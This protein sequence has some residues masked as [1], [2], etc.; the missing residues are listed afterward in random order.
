MPQMFIRRGRVLRAVGLAAALVVLTTGGAL[1]GAGGQGTLTST[2]QFRNIELFP[3]QPIT[4]PC[5]GAT[6]TLS[7]TARTG[8][9]HTTSFSTGPELWITSTAEGTATF[10]PDDPHGVTASGHFA[11]WF[12][13]SLNN[14]NEASTTTSMFQLMGTDGS[15]IHV[16][17]VAHVSISA[18]G[19]VTVASTTPAFIADRPRIRK[20]GDAS[21]PPSFQNNQ[22]AKEDDMPRLLIAMGIAMAALEVINAPMIDGWVLAVAFAVMFVGFSWWFARGGAMLPAVLLGVMFAI[23]LA[24]LPVYPRDTLL[25]WIMQG[26]TLVL[27]GVGLIA[28][29]S[30]LVPLVRARRRPALDTPSA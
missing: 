22:L 30:T 14:R 4:N 19:V 26:A 2:Q 17:E 24:F 21:S 23:E 11:E 3:P 6:G 12:G 25:E 20:G 7:A 28:A 9:F 8:V 27:S 29:I 5:T 15:H 18:N 10:T 16:H 13:V 1:A